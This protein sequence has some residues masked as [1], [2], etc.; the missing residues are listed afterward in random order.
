MAK[1]IKSVSIDAPVEKGFEY[2]SVPANLPEF[3]PSL[4]EVKDVQPLPSGGHKYGWVYKMAGMRF[5][6]STEDKEFIANQ[7]VVAHTKGGI[8]STIV[9]SYE[10]EGGGTKVTL[11]AEYTVPVPLLGRL[12]EPFI[13]RQNQHEAELLLANLKAR[14]EV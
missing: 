10:G 14:M 7:R 3:W 13:V 2:A 8:E 9:W 6:G 12:A 5:D 4:V 11:E 1:V